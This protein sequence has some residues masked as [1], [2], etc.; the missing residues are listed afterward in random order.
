MT[1]GYGAVPEQIRQ[2]ANDITDVVGRVASTVWS[3]PS[4]DYG[5][6]G[7]QTGWAQFIEMMRDH[8][9]E[10]RKQAETHST[11]LFDAV[12]T[13][14]GLEDDAESTLGA[15]GAALDSVGGGIAGGI[16]GALGGATAGFINPDIASRLNPTTEDSASPGPAGTAQGGP[17]Y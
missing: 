6:P 8:V 9:E 13:Y 4:G 2:A 11:G 3:G 12:T 1:G 14:L 5:H 15:A 17:L 10:L 7:V 16:G